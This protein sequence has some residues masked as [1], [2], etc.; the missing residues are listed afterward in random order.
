MPVNPIRQTTPEEEA[1]LRRLAQPPVPQP[2]QGMRVQPTQVAP[3]ITTNVVK[4]QGPVGPRSRNPEVTITPPSPPSGR[5]I[6]DT[7]KMP[8]IPPNLPPQQAGAALRSQ[9]PGA[10]KE[11]VGAPVRAAGVLADKAI[12]AVIP[13]K[14]NMAT[15]IAESDISAGPA[16]QFAKGLVM[17]ASPPRPSTGLPPGGRD[18]TPSFSDTRTTGPE[19][20]F[21][22]TPTPATAAPAP[23]GGQS[24]SVPYSPV[25]PNQVEQD[26]GRPLPPPGMVEVIRPSAAGGFQFTNE[27]GGDIRP[28]GMDDRTAREFGGFRNA[29]LTAPDAMQGVEILRGA[30]TNARQAEAQMI[31]ARAAQA[32]AQT[33]ASALERNLGSEIFIADPNDMSKGSI[34]FVRRDANGQ[35]VIEQTP[36]TSYRPVDQYTVKLGYEVTD[37]TGEKVKREAVF[38]TVTGEKIADSGEDGA[39]ATGKQKTKTIQPPRN[40]PPEATTEWNQAISFAGQYSNVESE[41]RQIAMDALRRKYPQLSDEAAED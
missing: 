4:P 7:A 39:A 37:R 25:G 5:P 36:I 9:L 2:P 17:G 8:S 27:L 14:T 18:R 40:L 41:M 16:L 23:A 33:R 34:G 15:A 32:E 12:S 28:V 3:G 29:G 24:L 1:A 11:L 6:I 22:R 20:R 31:Q 10:A 35:L 26:I 38:N 19:G 30:E 21:A 13:G